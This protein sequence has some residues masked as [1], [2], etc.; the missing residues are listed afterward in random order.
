MIAFLIPSFGKEEE[1]RRQE[2][3][4]ASSPNARCTPTGSMIDD[5]TLNGNPF[6]STLHR[7]DTSAMSA[8]MVPAF[9][10]APLHYRPIEVASH[11]RRWYLATPTTSGDYTRCIKRERY[12]VHINGVTP[13]IHVSPDEA[14][15]QTLHT[16]GD[17]R[18]GLH[19]VFGDLS[20]GRGELFLSD[21]ASFWKDA[22]NMS[23]NL[24]AIAARTHIS[25]HTCHV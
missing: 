3:A 25:R 4:S 6:W 24:R 8:D 21:A 15:G 17:G 1:Q 13:D 16:C 18:C 19:A 9:A 7:H 23:R 22:W 14:V 11:T 2:A 12:H 10:A 20:A 5:A